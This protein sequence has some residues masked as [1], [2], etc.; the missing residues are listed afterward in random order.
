MDSRAGPRYVM[1]HDNVLKDPR[2][3]LARPAVQQFRHADTLFIH[4]VWYEADH[5]LAVGYFL[6]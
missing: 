3:P 4:T 1:A 5:K 6:N 2:K